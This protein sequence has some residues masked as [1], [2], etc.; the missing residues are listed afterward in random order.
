MI[1]ELEGVIEAPASEIMEVQGP[2]FENLSTVAIVPTRG[3]VHCL[4]A[5]SWCNLQWPINHRHKGPMFVK[6]L[7]VDAAYEG[8]IG[9]IIEKMPGY[10]FILTMEDDCAIPPMSL[11]RLVEAMRENPWIDGVSGLYCRK[12]LQ[13]RPHVYGHPDKPDDFALM[14][15]EGQTGIVECNAI[16]MGFSLYRRELFES[17]P[18][19]WFKNVQEIQ[20]GSLKRISQDLYFC[21]EAKKHSKRFAVHCDVKVGHIDQATDKIFMPYQPLESSH[22]EQM[23]A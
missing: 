20:E 14:D 18:R 22:S 23:D 7:Q 15:V 10:A 13:G 17:L 4:A 6:G 5:Q 21:M 12:E 19:P 1:K 16:P 8:G 9:Q 3:M 11:L 2:K